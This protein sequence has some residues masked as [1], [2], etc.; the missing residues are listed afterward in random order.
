MLHRQPAGAKAHEQSAARAGGCEQQAPHRCRA[1][2]IA[3]G[4]SLNVSD[5]ACS[6]KARPAQQLIS[7]VSWRGRLA[8]LQVAEQHYHIPNIR[9]VESLTKQR[10]PAVEAL[11]PR[12]LSAPCAPATIVI[13]DCASIATSCSAASAPH[14]SQQQPCRRRQQW[15]QRRAIACSAQPPR[16]VLYDAHDRLVPYEQVS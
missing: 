11:Q 10:P 4:V 9:V 14:R 3:M 15:R 6:R 5:N 8:R 16:V 12:C 7:L 1:S 2:L 13:M